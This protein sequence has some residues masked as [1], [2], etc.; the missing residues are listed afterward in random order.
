MCR[1]KPFWIACAVILYFLPN[2]IFAKLALNDLKGDGPPKGLPDM[3][4]VADAVP[5]VEKKVPKQLSRWGLLLLLHGGGGG[6]RYDDGGRT[7]VVGGASLSSSAKQR[8]G[9]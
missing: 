2:I 6:L 9:R 7:P 5:K 8:F 3:S 4:H 1:I